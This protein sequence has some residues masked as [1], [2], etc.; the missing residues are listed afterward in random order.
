MT[1]GVVLVLVLA[2]LAACGGAESTVRSDWEDANAGRLAREGDDALPPLPPVPRAENLV[3]FSSGHGPDF[4][5]Y[6]DASSL[7]VGDG[8]VRYV[9]VARSASGAENIAYEV[10]NCRSSEYRLYAS[11]RRDGSWERLSAPW[12]AL[13][14]GSPAQR[15][16]AREYF[17]PRRVAVANV[18]EA[19]MALRRGGHPLADPPNPVSGR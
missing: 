9:L 5:F 18:A 19:A 12:R 16:L 11:A 1:R 17:C 13:G 14:P 4:R 6:V 15:A 2:A 7:N 8:L 10:L 3:G